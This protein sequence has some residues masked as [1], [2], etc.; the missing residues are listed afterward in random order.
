MLTVK[1]GILLQPP[2]EGGQLRNDFEMVDFPT[3]PV[4]TSSPAF[5]FDSGIPPGDADDL[6]CVVTGADLVAD[7]DW[8]CGLVF[9][10]QEIQNS[11]KHTALLALIGQI[12]NIDFPQL[13]RYCI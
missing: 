1:R 4:R 10:S 3:D 12:K 5:E 8:G 11:G 7:I 13:W 9:G 2:G 6:T